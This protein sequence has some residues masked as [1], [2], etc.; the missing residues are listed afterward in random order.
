[1]TITPYAGNNIT[2]TT[3]VIAVDKVANV[4]RFYDPETLRETKSL[5]VPEPQAHEL[6]ISHDRR[7]A[8]V[9]LYGDGIYGA[10]RKP[11]NKV[12]VID[13]IARS[14]I[15]IIPL[16]EMWAP[17]GMVAASDGRLWLVADIPNKLVVVNPGRRS[18]EAAYDCPAKGA[19]QMAMLPDESK[20]Y[21]SC[22]E[23]DLSVFDRAR[24]VWTA[25]VPMRAPGV[26]SGN[27]SGSEGV[28]PTPAGDRVIAIDNANSD[29]RVIDARS[30]A[31]IDR[32]PLSFTPPTNPRRSRL[33]KLMLSP[34]GRHL[35]ATAYASAL[36]WVID[37]TDLRHQIV[38]PVAKGPQGMAFPPDGKSV[39]VASHDSGLL[40]RIDLAEPRAVAAYDGGSGIEVLAYY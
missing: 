38:V 8:F 26:E 3:G 12:L 19:H 22:K 18:V 6:A 15:D 27:G 33:A 28:M 20:V 35:V 2:G 30:D 9:P 29:L 16:G 21:V 37:A 7:M 5:A 11:N 4:I 13:L 10:N 36:A 39:L 23:G 40:T 32:I 24:R 31:E 17:H 1:M 25:N 14:L 34:D